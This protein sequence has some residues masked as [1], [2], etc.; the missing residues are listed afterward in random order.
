MAFLGSGV[1]GGMLA[2][3]G[4]LNGL[5]QGLTE[6]G[7]EQVKENLAVKMDKLAQAREEAIT[8]LQGQ[9]Q[10]DLSAQGAQQNQ[11]LESQREGH[12][13]VT[14]GKE[15]D[16]ATGQT[17][18]KLKAASAAAGATR[19]FEGQQNDL[20]RKNQLARTNRSAEA[21][22]NSAAITAAS[23]QSNSSKKQ[24]PWKVHDLVKNTYDKSGQV[25]LSTEKQPLLQNPNNQSVYMQNGD[26]F[27]R[28]NQD[29]NGFAY[30]PK[31]L[32]R[33][34]PA[35]PAMQALLADPLGTVDSGDRKGMTKLDAFE[36]KFH[37]IPAAAIAKAQQAQ[38]SQTTSS[39]SSLPAGL[40]KRLGAA[41]S[42]QTGQFGGGPQG[43]ENPDSG[44]ADNAD[45]NDE[46][47]ND[48]QPPFQSSAMGAYGN[49]A[50]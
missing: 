10:K 9:Q 46:G 37:Y 30:D 29:T 26:R 27:I 42:S 11:A 3:A 14:L 38:Q 49:T 50:N 6:V 2:A 8:R 1:G 31:S 28:Y 20:N 41:S 23:R 34:E 40:L 45:Q 33:V 5:G 16:F 7:R 47:E 17:N 44:A 24:Q 39:S 12:E 43:E 15:E 25:V 22:E 13:D 21:R 48:A 32:R 4:A 35:E 18:T 36:D 19:E